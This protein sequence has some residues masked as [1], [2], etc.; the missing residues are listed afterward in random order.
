MR[1]SVE[2]CELIRAGAEGRVAFFPNYRRRGKNLR[3]RATLS[4]TNKI[5][6]AEKGAR[7]E[8]KLDL[9]LYGLW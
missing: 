2:K 3:Y 7:D 8:S 6:R 5:G 1:A 9:D 4:G